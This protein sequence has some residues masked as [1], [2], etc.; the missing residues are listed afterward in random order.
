M[1]LPITER[2]KVLAEQAEELSVH[3]SAT[4]KERI[5][6]QGG[7]IYDYAPEENAPTSNDSDKPVG[8]E[9]SRTGD[10]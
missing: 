6:R 3:Y 2:K 1:E 4:R 7:R 9:G 8:E 10:L 5:S